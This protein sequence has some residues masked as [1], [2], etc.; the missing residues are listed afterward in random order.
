MRN[1]PKHKRLLLL[2]LTLVAAMG[3]SGWQLGER[4]AS[5]NEPE[6]SGVCCTT[7]TG[8]PGTDLCYLPGILSTLVATIL[9][10]PDSPTCGAGLCASEGL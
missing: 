9:A 4:S 6:E 5:A 1:K 2:Y 7:S 10:R 3:Y 8:C